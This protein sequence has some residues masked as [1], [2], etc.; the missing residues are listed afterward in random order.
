MLNLIFMLIAVA[1]AGL[2]IYFALKTP[3]GG[4]EDMSAH[5]HPHQPQERTMTEPEIVSEITIRVIHGPDGQKM[6]D[7]TWSGGNPLYY[8]G[9]LEHV[10]K[11]ILKSVA[12]ARP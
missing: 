5:S 11:S 12:E 4:N 9:L 3:S 8:V 10:K 1:G 2:S 6:L 7:A